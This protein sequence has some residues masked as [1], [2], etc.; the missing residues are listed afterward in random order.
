MFHHILI[1][2][3]VTSVQSGNYSL[4][5]IAP[6]VGI[7]SSLKALQSNPFF[8]KN[9]LNSA[10]RL[11]IR[12]PASSLN[13]ESFLKGD[14]F[15]DVLRSDV[16][17][18]IL[19]DNFS[20]RAPRTPFPSPE[21][22]VDA[23]HDDNDEIKQKLKSFVR[24]VEPYVRS[25]TFEPNTDEIL[26]NCMNALKSFLKEDAI[27]SFETLI[28]KYKIYKLLQDKD[29]SIK[30]PVELGF[31]EQ[32][33]V[34]TSLLGS[35][36]YGTAYGA[37]LKNSVDKTPLVMKIYHLKEV[38]DLRREK[39][40]LEK[41]SR[42]VLYDE[43]LWMLVYKQIPG[44]DLWSL[45]TKNENIEMYKDEY[46]ELSKNFYKETGYIH[47]DIR[48]PN[49]IVDSETGKLRLIDFGKSFKPESEE[50]AV[51]ALAADEEYAMKEYQH[52]DLLIKMKEV[53]SNNKA[54][55]ASLEIIE[56]FINWLTLYSARSGEV[57]PQVKEY[58]R[59]LSSIGKLD[60]FPYYNYM[61]NENMEL[62][63]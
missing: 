58:F 18:S 54:D 17:T 41:L 37:Y 22:D 27:K 46:M 14:I 34:L 23:V 3:L 39:I 33:L 62:D 52:C 29:F 12:I 38:Q 48:P 20:S 10:K 19:L 16:K 40:V 25:F 61:Y 2:L 63:I 26:N 43:N 55:D 51:K 35:G 6:V 7:D 32:A 53:Y 60:R 31:G 36:R 56:D 24:Y 13:F 49:V 9:G 4:L 47:G 28:T 30:F 45:M 59:Y 42:L 21:S 1:L 5:I 44:N 8:V 50:D 15:Q 11:R 57:R